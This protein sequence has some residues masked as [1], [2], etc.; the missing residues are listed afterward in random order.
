[1]RELHF[2]SRGGEAFCRGAAAGVPANPE[3]EKGTRRKRGR[4]SI[5]GSPYGLRIEA[6][7]PTSKKTTPDP[8]S[9]PIM[10]KPVIYN[11][12]QQKEPRDRG[13]THS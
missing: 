5:V 11:A 2:L 8:L 10:P 3:E 4:E 13:R 7:A 9:S 6:V 1:M 12:E